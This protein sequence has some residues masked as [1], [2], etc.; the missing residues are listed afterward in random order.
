VS[1]G[2]EQLNTALRAAAQAGDAANV[3]AALEQGVDPN[4]A[5][6]DTGETALML[7][8]EFSD[9]TQGHLVCMEALVNAGAYIDQGDAEG[10]TALMMAARWGKTAA[11]KWL[12][13]AGADWWQS[14]TRHNITALQ[15]A[16]MNNQEET[17]AALKAVG[18]KGGGPDPNA[19]DAYGMTGLYRAAAN[20]KIDNMAALVTAGANIDYADHHGGT[21]LIVATI[22]GHTEAIK[23]LL[24][25][26][27]NITRNKI[28]R[29]ALDYAKQRVEM[30]FI[31]AD[32]QEAVDA[33]EI[34][35]Q[36]HWAQ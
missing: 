14:R 2:E 35:E 31:G 29:T 9:I 19:T 8:A 7:A 20:N 4:A 6:K 27:A 5:D 30:G 10:Y 15:W 3:Q 21:A 13:A 12:L 34:W 32:Q 17:V 1:D 16:E 25:N 33:L 22:N 36:T 11:V 24:D 26:G 28:G 18:A 23:W